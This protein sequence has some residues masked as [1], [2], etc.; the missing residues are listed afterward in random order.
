MII[1]LL[2]FVTGNGDRTL[3]GWLRPAAS[4]DSFFF[5]EAESCRYK[6]RPLVD[7]EDG[8]YIFLTRNATINSPELIEV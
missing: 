1:K 2:T 3:G 5:P 6:N 7:F 8:K 4:G